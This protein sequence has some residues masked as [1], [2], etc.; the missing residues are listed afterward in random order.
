MSLQKKV[1][2]ALDETRLLITGASVLLGFQLNGP[3]RDAFDELAPTPRL[4]AGVAFLL[5]VASV[6]A[7]IAP[8]AWHRIAERGDEST[9]LVNAVSALVVVALLPFA[10]SLGL[11][12]FII[13]HRLYGTP[14]GVAAGTVFFAL[15]AVCWYGP[16]LRR[17]CRH[18]RGGG[19]PEEHRRPPL[20]IQI[21]QM[22]TEARVVLPGAQALL[23]FQLAVVLTRAFETLPASSRLLHAMALGFLALAVILLMT[24]AA[25]HRLAHGGDDTTDTLRV[26][27]ALVT[28][29]S[30]PLGLGIAFDVYVVLTHIARSSSVGAV[31]ALVA[32]LVLLGLWL[33]LPLWVRRRRESK[34]RG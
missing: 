21:D 24:P 7:L 6:G 28:A 32:A 33:A 15:A 3:F 22:L 23:G 34:R 29:A 10:L 13:G 1:K 5:M 12:I 19:A 9:R 27:G 11:D 16:G 8:S 17:L 4:L 14:A 18:H 30:V 2:V 26:G 20:E 25:Y 31:A